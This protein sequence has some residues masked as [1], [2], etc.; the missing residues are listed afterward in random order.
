MKR[1]N[2]NIINIYIL[3][4]NMTD[5]VEFNLGQINLFQLL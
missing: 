2:K 3:I 1:I 5:I 4:K